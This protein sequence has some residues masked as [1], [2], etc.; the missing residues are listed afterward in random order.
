M[1]IRLGIC[2]SSRDVGPF[3]ASG[4]AEQS[5]DSKAAKKMRIEKTVESRDMKILNDDLVDCYLRACK[6]PHMSL[7]SFEF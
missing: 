5:T 3:K 1:Q 6:W 2:A 7:F 4:S